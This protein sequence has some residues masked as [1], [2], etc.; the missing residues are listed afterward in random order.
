MHTFT[1]VALAAATEEPLPIGLTGG[2]VLIASLLVTAA[3]LLYL[4][5]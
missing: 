1:A 2:V 3:W 5:R 4:Y